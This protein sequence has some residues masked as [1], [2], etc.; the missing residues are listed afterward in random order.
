MFWRAAALERLHQFVQSLLEGLIVGNAHHPTVLQG[1]FYASLL[2][3][4]ASHSEST[5]S[6]GGRAIK[7]GQAQMT[8][9]GTKATPTM[10]PSAQ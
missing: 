4:P 3:S 1:A 9:Q 7:P 2:L 8:P 6:A 5:R 10:E